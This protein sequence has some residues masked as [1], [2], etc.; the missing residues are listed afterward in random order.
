VS[1]LARRDILSKMAGGELVI[2][3][4]LDSANQ[5]GDDAVDL[6]LGT[7]AAI[8]R[9]SGQTSVDPKVYIEDAV[10]GDHAREERKRRKLE[11][12]SVPFG[13]ALVLHAGSLILVPTFEWIRLPHDVKGVVTARSS[14]GRE[15]LGVATAAFIHPCYN[16]VIT[17]ELTNFGQIPIVLY[18]GMRIAQVAFYQVDKAEPCDPAKFSQFA[19]S[20]EAAAGNITKGD[21]GF[22]PPP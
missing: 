11:H 5:I 22:I 19:M 15:G 9:G 17:L 4:I 10:R 1:V 12:V 16:G 6:R 13:E 2:T 8:I 20:F 3:P 14:W 21:E 7:M 18:P